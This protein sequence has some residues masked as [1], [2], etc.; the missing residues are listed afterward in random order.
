[1][2]AVGTAGLVVACM[3]AASAA[4]GE[5]QARPPAFAV[6]AE[7]VTV[8]M[9]VRDRKDGILRGL[10]AA[11]VEVYEDGVRQDL[12]SLDFVEP[13][14][15][16]WPGLAVPRPTFVAIAFDR[17]SGPARLF[18]RDAVLEH[19]AQTPTGDV[20]MGL[21]SIDRAIDTLQPFTRD[22]EA[23][24]DALARS[25]AAAS[26]AGARQRDAVRKAYGG[27]AAGFGQAHVAA[28]ELAGEPE[29]RDTEDEVVRRLKILDSRMTE[30]FESLERDQQGFATA[31]A[32]L[33]LIAA[34][35]PLPG[36]KAVL[37]FSEGLVI[38]ADVEASF[39]AVAAAANR[40][41]V[42]IYGAD[43]GGLRATSAG[44]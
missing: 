33:S 18:A 13:T 36:R 43:A 8:D 37:L 14:A 19:L 32:L 42:S 12:E 11:D 31:H 3:T 28:A 34:L 9:V 30:S 7:R 1:M 23:L 5:D 35:A 2:Q 29:C 26:F 40:A 27:L 10:T 24:R 22:R 20:W 16:S 41:N 6:T 15:V 4:P 38:P 44:D 25:P 39:Q 17:L 21:F